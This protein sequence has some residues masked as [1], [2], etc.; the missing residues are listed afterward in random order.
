MPPGHWCLFGQF[1]SHRDR[2]S[3]DQDVKLFFALANAELDASIACWGTKRVFDSV[4][5]V[6]AIHFLYGGKKVRAWAGPGLGT[7]LIDGKDWQPYQ[8]LTVVT[9]PFPE[10]ISGHSTFSAAGAEILRR[11]T[12]SDR[13]GA[14]VTI[15]AGASRVEPGLTPA[16]PVTLSW[17]TFTAAA[18]QAGISRRYGGIHFANG[19]L[20]G[21][22]VGRAIGT[23]VWE[24]A[25]TYFSGTA[26]P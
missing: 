14:S 8:A 11:F 25:L 13:F 5:P 12:G 17:S 23:R 2:L 1:V 24:K 20:T 21:R 26:A 9:P 10:F 19:D 16:R 22:Y 6:T 4:R 15:P 18:D 3:L 7:R